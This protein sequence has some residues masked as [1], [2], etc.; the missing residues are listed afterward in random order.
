[1]ALRFN[2]ISYDKE[3]FVERVDPKYYQLREKLLNFREDEKVSICNFGDIISSITDGEHA[4]QTFVKDGVLFLKNSSIK[5]FDISQNDGFYITPED[6]KRLS[7]SAI[8]PQDILFTTI[9]HLGSAAIVPEKFGEANM[10]QNFVKITID[11]RIINPYYVTCFLNSKF[12]RQQINALLTGNIQSI[13]TYPK[14]KNIRILYPKH[15]LDQELIAK[16]YVEAIN[17]S[18]NALKKIKMALELFEQNL[19]ANIISDD[20]SK[21]FNVN[22]E[23]FYDIQHMWTPKSHYPKYVCTEEKIKKTHNCIEL[24]KVVDIKKGDE[25]GSDAYSDYLNKSDSDI[26]FVRTSD[27]YNYQVDLCPDNFVDFATYKELSQNVCP[28]DILFTKDGKIAEIA[29][30]TKA[31]VALYQ[32]GIIIM[33]INEKGQGLGLTQEYLFTSIMCKKVGRYTAERYT[34]TASTI[35]HLKEHYIKEM[36]IPILD[37][38]TILEITNIIS[39]AFRC[40]EKRKLLIKECQ[41]MINDITIK[42]F[43]S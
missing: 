6:H 13:L 34:V 2:S 5:D 30:V 33:R 38:K 39:E 20:Y 12:A 9:G 4:G 10:N 14:I 1:M 17:L 16:K 23:D 36:I 35:P 25:P 11:K 21:T 41:D 29:M 26:P 27:I 32:S 42:Y 8:K 40:I 22:D 28:G 19:N 31:D 43:D 3:Q 7:R 37:K 18:Q 15:R 24:G